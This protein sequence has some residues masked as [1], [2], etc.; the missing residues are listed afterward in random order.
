MYINIENIQKRC[1]ISLYPIKVTRNNNEN[2]MTRYNIFLP[3][4]V[5][6]GIDK[7]FGNCSWQIISNENATRY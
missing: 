2:R 3:E 4:I 5:I 6:K 1:S 7:Y